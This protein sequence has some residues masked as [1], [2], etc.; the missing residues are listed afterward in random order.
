MWHYVIDGPTKFTLELVSIY[1]LNF[2][3]VIAGAK[4]YSPPGRFIT[5]ISGQLKNIGMSTALK[6]HRRIFDAIYC[7]F[8]RTIIEKRTALACQ[9]VPSH[10]FWAK[11]NILSISVNLCLSFV[12]N[13]IRILKYVGPGVVWRFRV[14]GHEK[15]IQLW[16]TTT[17][18]ESV[19]LCVTKMAWYLN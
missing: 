15:K 3:N 7:L 8:S 14:C 19:S 11:Q 5:F 9:F 12:C 18:V 13:L 17:N 2:V 6:F 4:I 1:Y 16:D 10:V